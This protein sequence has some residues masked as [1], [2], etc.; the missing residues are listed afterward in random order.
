MD[1]ESRS[2]RVH[3]VRSW[4]SARLAAWDT[5]LGVVL[6]SATVILSGLD[7]VSIQQTIAMALAATLTTLGGL[8]AWIVPDAWIAWRR[9]FRRGCEAGVVSRS[10]VMSADLAANAVWEVRLA[11]VMSCPRAQ[12]CCVCRCAFS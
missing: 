11:R 7:V 4:P 6:S 1:T 5:A 10:Y 8:I 9:G 12:D 2:R 3:A